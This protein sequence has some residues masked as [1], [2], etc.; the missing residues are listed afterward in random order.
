MF[1]VLLGDVRVLRWTKRT[2]ALPVALLAA[3]APRGK[4]AARWMAVP[5]FV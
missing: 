4:D 1:D 3:C 2:V 5:T